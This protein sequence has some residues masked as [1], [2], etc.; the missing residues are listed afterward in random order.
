MKAVSF[1]T[2]AG[3]TNIGLIGGEPTLHPVFQLLLEMLIADPKVSGITLYTN[4][5]LMDRFIPQ[6]IHP[7]VNV[8]VNV[9]SP[10]VIGEKAFA[11]IQKNL[12][13]LIWK[14]YRKDQINLGIN[15]YSNEMDY[16]FIIELL[17][18]YKMHRLRISLSVPD[19][20]TCGDMNSLSFFR[21]NKDFILEFFRKMDSIQVM[22]YYD[23]NCPP[24]CI[25]TDEEKKWLEEYAA[26]YPEIHSNLNGQC[27]VCSPVIDILPDLQ[28]VR[29]F[30]MSDFLKV[31]I[32]DFHNI[33]DLFRFF[34]NEIDAN[35]FKI[36]T[37][38]ECKTCY[39]RKTQ[40]CAAGCLGFKS[41][42]IHA[43]NS[44]IDKLER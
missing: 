19:F 36:S 14:Y 23:C 11:D 2:S 18:R 25:W 5:L 10:L 16:S 27:S 33:R 35:A 15:L 17:Q 1:L 21:K 20:S 43:C 28:A 40:Q 32:D 9:N 41:E 6:I 3:S 12:D 13:T 38:D 34:L 7:K 42:K 4:G 44:A 31:P 8:L 22:P 24:D 37:S 39:E 30:G 26:R 29:C